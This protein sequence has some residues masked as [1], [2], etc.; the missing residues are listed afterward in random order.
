MKKYLGFIIKKKSG[1]VEIAIPKLKK[2]ICILLS[3]DDDCNLALGKACFIQKNAEGE[4]EIVK[5]RK[6]AD[7]I[8][9]YIYSRRENTGNIK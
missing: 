3:L 8:E 9:K 6:E 2:E 1:I 7:Q 5:E 4:Y